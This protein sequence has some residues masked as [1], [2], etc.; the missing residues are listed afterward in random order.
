[1]ITPAPSSYVPGF[2]EDPQKIRRDSNIEKLKEDLEYET[3]ITDLKIEQSSDRLRRDLGTKQFYEIFGGG[4]QERAIRQQQEDIEVARLQSQFDVQRKE[5]IETGQI[6]PSIV[7][8]AE[9]GFFEKIGSS[10]QTQG[11]NI[12]GTVGTIALALVAILLF[13]KNK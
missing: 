3:Q 11:A 12:S 7:A 6:D 13:R 10:L 4:K 5:L 9:Q 1:V 8:S 2:K